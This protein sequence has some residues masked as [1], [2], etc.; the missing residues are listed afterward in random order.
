MLGRVVDSTLEATIAGSFSRTGY[1]LRK[2][3]QR[4]DDPPRIDGSVIA[5]TGASSG[6]GMA[7]AM[8]LGRLG[9][10]LWLVGRDP[11]RTVAAAGR[12]IAAGAPWAEPAVLDVSEGDALERFAQQVNERGRLDGIVH[13]AGALLRHYEENSEGTE[14]TVATHVLAPYRLTRH[15]EPLLLASPA[16]AVVILTSGGLYAERF[17]LGRLESHPDGYD[18]VRAYARAKRAQVVLVHQ[19][20]HRW[21][22]HGVD[23]YA[24]HPG[25]VDTPGLKAGLPSFSR[26][27]PLLR[28]PDQGADTAVWLVAGGAA[29]SG[30][31]RHPVPA[32]ERA[33]LWLDRRRR[34]EYYLPWTRSADPR[35]DEEQLWDW[36]S[37]RSGFSSADADDNLTDR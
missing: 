26:L 12:V 20:A 2:R 21:R 3:I 10:G 34:A 33:G 8:A 36:C 11:E 19:W 16:S 24:V 4:W 1:E 22:F 35:A 7:A 14:R 30:P 15:L 9:A 17:D 37:A 25:W 5:V 32:D 29:Q 13:C 18:G 6:I 27:G 28:H 23:A 31:G